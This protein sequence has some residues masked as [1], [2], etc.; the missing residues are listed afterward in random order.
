MYAVIFIYEKGSDLEGYSEMDT[1][2]IELAKEHPGYIKHSFAGD[3]QK[4]IFI[5][6]W[7]SMEHI[8]AWKKHPVHLQAKAEGKKRWYKWYISQICKV[9]HSHEMMPHP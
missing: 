7:E 5:S 6:Y 8:E 1:Y 3:G 2:T 9:E 4:N